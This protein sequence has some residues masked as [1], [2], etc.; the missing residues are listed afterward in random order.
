MNKGDET[1]KDLL[2]PSQ[3]DKAYASVEK[4]QVMNCLEVVLTKANSLGQ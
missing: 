2:F 3:E 4:A 1:T